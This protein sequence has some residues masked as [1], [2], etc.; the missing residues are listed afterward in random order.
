VY[1]LARNAF[2]SMGRRALE[3]GQSLG[4]SRW[5]GFRRV[6]LP[7]ARPW[8]AGG[9]MLALMET[10][11]DFG[12]VAIFNFDAF[13]S[14]IYKAWFSL[15]SLP[16]AKQLAS[17]LVLMVLL[18]LWLEQRSRGRRAYTQAGKAARRPRLRREGAAGV[19]AGAACALVLTLAFALPF[20][21]LL[22]WAGAHWAEDLDADFLGHV[23]NS[24]LLAW[25]AAG[26]VA[27]TALLLSY[28]AR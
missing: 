8:I 12:T 25:L 26:L 24:L 22:V 7:M 21:Q 2:A 19:L 9:L 15:F 6:A 16:A 28:A 18:L 4:L 14:A 10:L 13:T 11:A 3:V 20:G 17:L 1:L 5:Q 23:A 27:L